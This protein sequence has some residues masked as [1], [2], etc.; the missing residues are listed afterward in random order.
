MTHL[1]EEDLILIYYNEPGV[2]EARAHLAE[3]QTCRAE[4]ESL[5][6]ALN[7]C[8][9]WTAPEP[10]PE[11]TRSTW[12]RLAPQL[13]RNALRYW[14]FPFFNTRVWIAASTAA[15]LI[16]VAF[17]A[18]RGTSS[19][20]PNTPAHPEQAL[21][22]GLS[23]QARERILAIS[24]ADHLDR[25]GRLLTEVANL[26]GADTSALSSEQ[27]RAQDLVNEGRLMRQ[28][29]A[30]R[31]GAATLPLFDDV[32][33]FM[34]ELANAPDR[35]DAKEIRDLKRHMDSESLLFKVRIIES[36]LRTSGRTS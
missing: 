32:E 11:F 2:G 13:R 28:W 20:Y 1:S 9:N 19:R 4:A 7:I 27:G 18:G 25:A 15:A 30:S 34:M 23:P 16:I 10:G 22:S 12:S 3:C 24:L 8:D 31:N 17:L 26:G 14:L 6:A 21:T 5:A 29:L 33:R 36:N 35:V